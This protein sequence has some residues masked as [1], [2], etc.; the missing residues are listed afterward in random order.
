MSEEPVYIQLLEKVEQE[1]LKKGRELEPEGGKENIERA[2]EARERVGLD[3]KA[4]ESLQDTA[5]KDTT[6]EPDVALVNKI[7]SLKLDKVPEDNL[8]LAAEISP[9]VLRIGISSEMGRDRSVAF[10]EALGRKKW[11]VE[12]AVEVLHRDVDKR[13]Q[14]KGKARNGGKGGR[15]QSLRVG[16][17]ANED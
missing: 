13:G 1:A 3:E 17:M 10:V 12:W 11:P 16:D 9:K 7:D 4:P 15:R 2:K 8:H 6:Q 14:R 5:P